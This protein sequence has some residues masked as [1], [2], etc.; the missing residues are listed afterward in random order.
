MAPKGSK[1]RE[2]GGGHGGGP[3]PKR[4]L[5]KSSLPGP[6]NPMDF[7]ALAAGNPELLQQLTALAAG[8]TAAAPIAKTSNLS[9]EKPT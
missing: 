2:S 6:S 9:G 3:A 4:G 1:K 8:A 7:L 5:A